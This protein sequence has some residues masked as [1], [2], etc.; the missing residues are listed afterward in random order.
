MSNSADCACA[1]SNNGLV[2][3][4]NGGAMQKIILRAFVT[5]ALAIMTNG[6]AFVPLDAKL[7]PLAPMPQSTIGA[8][9]AIH[10]RFIDER[11]KPALG[12]RAVSTGTEASVRAAGLPAFMEKS[13]RDGLSAKGYGLVTG[14]AGAASATFHLRAFQFRVEEGFGG[15][16]QNMLALLRVDSMRGDKTYTNVYRFYSAEQVMFN[17][18]DTVINARINA[19]LS[20][21]LQQALSDPKLDQLLIAK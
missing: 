2:L 11:D 18:G 4:A 8:G 13:L 16:N 6:C 12:K 7:V 14:Q 9:T 10:F 20:S 21:I 5:A 15:G 3:A 19:A 17:S 1:V